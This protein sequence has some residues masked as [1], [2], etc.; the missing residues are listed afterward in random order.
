VQKLKIF[1]PQSYNTFDNQ[2][3]K[4][5]N[6]RLATWL[7]KQTFVSL[8]NEKIVYQPDPLLCEIAVENV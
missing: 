1:V 3:S 4:F 6:W 7:S 2:A 5:K 8:D